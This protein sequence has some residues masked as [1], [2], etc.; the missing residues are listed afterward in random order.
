MT[1]KKY[2]TELKYAQW[3]PFYISLQ[4]DID[5][6]KTIN[7]IIR[8]KTTLI[9]DFFSLINALFNSTC[10]AIEKEMEMEKKLNDLENKIYDKKYL[11]D[12]NDNNNTN[13]LIIYQH[14]IIKDLENIFKTIVKSLSN[15]GLIPKIEKKER[16]D[17]GKALYN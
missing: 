8:K 7:K 6:I 1:N 13:K 17:K 5:H 15:E 12:L 3:N 9:D 16:K 10:F 2:E 11:R 14:K 4:K